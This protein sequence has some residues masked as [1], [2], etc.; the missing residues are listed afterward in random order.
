MDLASILIPVAL[1]IILLLIGLPIAFSL[2][3]SA[4]VGSAMIVGFDSTISYLGVH[5]F[6]S[7]G[8]FLL[9]P[10]PLFVLMGEILAVSGVGAAMF[11]AALKWFGRFRGGL[12]VASI[13]ACAIFAAMCGLSMAGAATIGIVA[14]PEMIRRGYDKGLATGSVTCAGTLGILIPPSLPFIMFGLVAEQSVGQLFMAGVLPGAMLTV[15]FSAYVFIRAWRQPHIAPGLSG[16]TWKDRVVSLKGLWAA[17]LLILAVLGSI[18]AGVATPTEAAGVGAFGA[19]MIGFARGS[20]TLKSML[21]AAWRALIVIGFV[22]FL[23][24]AAMFFS[25]YL[26]MTGMTQSLTVWMSSL[27]VSPWII[28]AGMC[29]ILI[30]L[31]CFLDSTAIILITTPLFLPVVTGF[32]FSPIWYGVILIMTIEIAFVTPPVGLNL[33][34]VSNIAPDIPLSTI[35]RGSIPFLLLA[36]LGIAIIMAFPQVALWLPSVMLQ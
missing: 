26:T 24:L 22:M 16:I 28:L 2:L 6:S 3:L 25:H 19:M 18:Y 36:V 17:I 9:T 27:P 12:S 1:L 8:K 33:Y 15:L 34:V 13:V 7:I 30:F 20:M 14:I 11:D 4:I 10:V 5:G 21:K 31:G 32:G 35:L 23:V 29:I